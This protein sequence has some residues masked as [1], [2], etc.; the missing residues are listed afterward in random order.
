MLS[1]ETKVQR[2]LDDRASNIPMDPGLGGGDGAGA[3]TNILME[4]APSVYVMESETQLGS[5][6]MRGLVWTES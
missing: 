1:E 2:A 3:W 4:F 6:M 5:C